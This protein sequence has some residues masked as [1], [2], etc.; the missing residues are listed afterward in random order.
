M[1]PQRFHA[2]NTQLA[3]RLV[4]EALGPEAVIISNRTVADGVEIIAGERQSE[5]A[6]E[7]LSSDTVSAQEPAPSLLGGDAATPG[8]TKRDLLDIKNLIMSEIAA[9]KIDSWHTR[10]PQRYELFKYFVDLGFDVGLM[11]KIISLLDDEKSYAELKNDVLSELE[12]SINCR[13]EFL[14]A[15][16]ELTGIMMIHGMTGAGKTTTTAK[17]AARVNAAHGPDSVVMVCADNRRMGAYQQLLGYG[18]ILEIP[19]LHVRKSNE[20]NEILSALKNTRLV[21]VDHAGMSPDEFATIEKSVAFQCSLPDIQHFLA[22]AATTQSASL[23][24]VLGAPWK[25]RLNGVIVTKLDEAVQLG[26]TIS[27]LIRNHS[28]CVFTSAGQNIQLDLHK[29]NPK[30]LIKSALELKTTDN[31]SLND[32]ANTAVQAMLNRQADLTH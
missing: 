32:P 26:E 14:P 25:D 22:V 24:T 31:V 1:H 12:W 8:V 5:S 10:D 13:S 17:I 11:S 16:D 7:A 28:P 21:V 30:Q 3:F 9:V 15:V 29:V 19:V 18:K 20:L 23:N 4:R 2:Q 6:A 27:C